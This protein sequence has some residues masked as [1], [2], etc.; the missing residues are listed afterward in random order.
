[1]SLFHKILI[2]IFPLVFS[3]NTIA[4]PSA[5]A[6]SDDPKILEVRTGD[7]I[8]LPL[9]C[10]SCRYIADEEQTEFSHSGVAI[11]DEKGEI[12]VAEALGKVKL[13]PLKNFLARVPKN[14]N[15]ALYRTHELD[16]L[17]M[18]GVSEFNE[19]KRTGDLC[20]ENDG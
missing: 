14:K 12:F 3:L 2:V 7:V 17:Y 4:A 10:Y 20:C 11:V 16:Q 18:L 9:D 13:V 8:L 15:A 5:A 19:F 6:N 1:M